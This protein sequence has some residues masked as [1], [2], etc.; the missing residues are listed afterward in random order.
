MTRRSTAVLLPALLAA[1]ALLVSG[2]ANADTP[3]APDSEGSG[4]T[5]APR[6]E[7]RSW[8]EIQE[9]GVLNVGTITDYPPNEFK[10]EDG[11]PTGWAVEL[12]EAIADDLDLDVEYELLLFDNILPRIQGGSIDLGVGSFTDTLERQEVV[13][14]VNYYEAGTLWAGAA[15]STVDPEQA[16][17]LTVAAMT[18]GTQ[19]LEELPERSEKCEAAGESPIEILPFTGQPE[20][21]QAVL[22]GRAD[23]FS[24]DSPVTIDAV[25]ALDGKLEVVGDMFDSA[26]YGFPVPK[27]G[28]I[29]EPV[30]ES[31][32]RLIDNGTYREILEKYSSESGAIDEATINVATE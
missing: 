2:C 4:S 21:T 10:T 15:G 12:V 6:A 30:R 24:A 22:D 14:F 3:G 19:H 25:V 7:G 17:G 18:G 23:A 29:A 27:G 28:E 32:Q 1:S 31:L 5:P 20:V 13:D 11:R 16:C 8:S 26:P 9:S